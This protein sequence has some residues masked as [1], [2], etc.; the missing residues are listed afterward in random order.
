MDGIASVGNVH[1]L[2][3]LNHNL[4]SQFL[5][6]NAKHLAFIIQVS[7]KYVTYQS[8]IGKPIGRF[9]EAH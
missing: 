6:D 2:K 8:S 7:L 1:T 5:H 3:I 4:T 9:S